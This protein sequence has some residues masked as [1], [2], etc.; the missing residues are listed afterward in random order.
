MPEQERGEDYSEDVEK[1]LDAVPWSDVPTTSTLPEQLY[2]WEII[3]VYGGLTQGDERRTAKAKVV[4]VLTILEPSDFNGRM[5]TEN[6]N[7]GTD[8]DPLAQRVETWLTGSSFG[9]TNLAKLLAF[10]GC[11]NWRQLKAK[12]FAC[13]TRNSPSA[14]DPARVYSNLV[15]SQYYKL[16]EVAPGTVTAPPKYTRR[17]RS[18]AQAPT[19][20]NGANAKIACPICSAEFDGG[21]IADHVKQCTGAPVATSA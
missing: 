14:N 11:A 3:D 19:G 20:T 5:H 13:F 2:N 9:A 15:H 6:F 10:C 12:K 8:N 4:M 7:I 17:Q 16:G 1:M 18:A 21:E